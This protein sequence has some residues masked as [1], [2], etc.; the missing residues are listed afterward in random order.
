[1][2]NIIKKDKGGN[3]RGEI[4]TENVIF[5]ILNLVFLSILILFLF[6]K[7]NSVVVIE[8]K[9][10]KQ[11]ALMMNS[12][13][14]G[15]TIALDMQDAIKIAEINNRNLH[16]EVVRIDGNQIGIQLREKGG[17]SYSF[18]KNLNVQTRFDSNSG[19]KYIFVIT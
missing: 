6:T 11:I 2:K 14:P 10:A 17:Y 8:E 9:Y 13:E 19:T 16:N 3:K 7:M 1:M 12:A 18:F 15:M 4:L 5:L